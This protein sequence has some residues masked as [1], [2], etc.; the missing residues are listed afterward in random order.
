MALSRHMQSISKELSY[1]VRID[2]NLRYTKSDIDRFIR[3][4]TNK[5]EIPKLTQHMKEK[6]TSLPKR[7]LQRY[8]SIG[9]VE[10]R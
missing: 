5:L 3:D 2:L 8:V 7:P 10:N 6:A 4:E 1:G 9:F